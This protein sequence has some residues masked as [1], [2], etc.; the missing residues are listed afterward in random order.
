MNS[1]TI[2]LDADV[3]FRDPFYDQVKFENWLIHQRQLLLELSWLVVNGYAL[4]VKSAQYK[5]LIKLYAS[6]LYS[7]EDLEKEIFVFGSNLKGVHGAGAAK[8]ARLFRGAKQGAGEGLQGQS[9]A[10]PT[11]DINIKALP[12]KTI[13]TH[14]ETFYE[15]ALLHPKLNFNVSRAGCG[16]AG[17]T[18]TDMMAVFKRALSNRPLPNNVILPYKWRK[19]KLPAITLRVNLFNVVEPPKALSRHQNV[20]VVTSAHNY[21]ETVEAVEG[22][23]VSEGFQFIRLIHPSERYG[24]KEADNYLKGLI[25]EWVW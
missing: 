3:R 19:D 17:Y 12:L 6:L 21:S 22:F 8:W 25:Q 2:Y 7:K 4:K 15:F 9:Y 14:V 5:Y 11:K 18:D 20:I 10:L 16:L 24:N 23:C 1:D 13:L